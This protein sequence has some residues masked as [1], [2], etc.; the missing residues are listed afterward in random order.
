VGATTLDAHKLTDGHYEILLCAKGFVSQAAYVSVSSGM[1]TPSRIEVELPRPRWVVFRYA[2]NRAGGPELTGPGTEAGRFAT[3]NWG[4][5]DAFGPDWQ[6]LQSGS[7]RAPVM[8][9]FGPGNGRGCAPTAGVTFDAIDRALPD[10]AYRAEERVLRP[11]QI[12]VCR[13]HDAP[14]GRSYSKLQVESVT[15]SEP[16]GVPLFRPRSVDV[17]L[18]EP[19]L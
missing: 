9:F 7:G 17:R 11:G 3:T 2:R 14:S 12:W 4:N 19:F 13:G 6:V 8:R 1:A 5:L 15:T 16:V 10:A 18:A